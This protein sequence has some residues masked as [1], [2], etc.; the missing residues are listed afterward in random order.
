M[1][2]LPA[3]AARERLQA[4]VFVVAVFT[5]LF[6]A[7]S[8]LGDDAYITFRVV[9]NFSTATGPSS[10]PASA[11]RPTRTHCGCSSSAPRTG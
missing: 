2:P 11:S 3:P 9:W 10:I 5:Y 8:W 4:Q 7:N 6:L 1:S